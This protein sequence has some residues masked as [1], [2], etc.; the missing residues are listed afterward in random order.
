MF[1]I[2]GKIPKSKFRVA[3]SGGSD[4]MVFVDFLR[5]FPKNDFELLHFNHGTEW[6]NEA[7]HFVRGYCEKTG[8]ILHVGRI[9]E[10][11]PRGKSAEAFWREQRYAFFKEFS[12]TPIITCHHLN[13]EIETW[14]MTCAVG[15]PSLIPYRNAEYS[16]IRPF[17]M[18]PKSEISAWAARHSINWVNDGSNSDVSK[19]RNLVRLEMMDKIYRLNPGIERTVA[20]M[21]RAK[22][23]E[24]ECAG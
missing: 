6:C 10:A 9:S 14:F 3:C 8:L 12:D 17:L 5:R 15:N 23:I 13:D 11:L 4:S 16:I 22:Y 18:V 20:G 7:E 19:R 21:V 1:E 2:L 24:S